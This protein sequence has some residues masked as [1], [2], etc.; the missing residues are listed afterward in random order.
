MLSIDMGCQKQ[1]AQNS[2]I[3]NTAKFN[4]ET[5][6]KHLNGYLDQGQTALRIA[7]GNVDYAMVKLLVENGAEI[8]KTDIIAES[9]RS[10]RQS[11][12]NESPRDGYFYMVPEQPRSKAFRAAIQLGHDELLDL[13]V[14]SEAAPGCIPSLYSPIWPS[15]VQAARICEAR[16]SILQL[17]LNKLER[18]S[19]HDH[20]PKYI[21]NIWCDKTLRLLVEKA[22]Y[23][24]LHIQ[25]LSLSNSCI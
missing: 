24:R 14:S 11:I 17:L 23:S 15:L 8:N 20:I 16:V 18:R 21:Q 1:Y 7:I 19:F 4:L 25:V 22:E 12:W 2:P 6:S 13:V 5:R 9:Y 3:L 10:C